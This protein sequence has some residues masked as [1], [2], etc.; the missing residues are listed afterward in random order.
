MLYF[1]LLKGGSIVIK[2]FECLALYTEDI[3]SSIDFYKSI[4]FLEAWRIERELPNKKI[5]TLVGFKFE[6]N[7]SS[8]IVI[9]NNPEIK[10]PD[11]ELYTDDVVKTYKEMKKNKEIHWIST[12]FKTESGH[13]AV[14]EAPDKNVFVLVGK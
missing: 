6:S 2:K 10:E 12:P 3:D 8:E 9:H 14:F 1:Y 11:I 4:G 7:N 13:V 5:W